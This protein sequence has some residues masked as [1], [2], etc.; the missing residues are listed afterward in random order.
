MGLLGLLH[1]LF[2]SRF[3]R[4]FEGRKLF[5][6]LLVELLLHLLFAL[7]VQ[8]LGVLAVLEMLKIGVV[9]LGVALHDVLEVLGVLEL[10]VLVE[11]ALAAVGL[12]AVLHHALVVPLD[13]RGHAADSLELTSYF[14]LLV[15]D[16]EGHAQGLLVLLLVR[17]RLDLLTSMR[18]IFCFSSSFSV[19]MFCSYGHLSYPPSQDDVRVVQFAVLLVVHVIRIS[20]LVHIRS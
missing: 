2:L 12:R 14:S 19:R 13:L 20:V 18:N 17:L 11:G 16:V 15:V 8:V 7:L 4:C 5:L 3:L 6:L 9:V 1:Q 10:D